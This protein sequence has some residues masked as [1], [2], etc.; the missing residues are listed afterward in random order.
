MLVH[1]QINFIFN[2]MSTSCLR[3]T[4]IANGKLQSK[5][6]LAINVS[7]TQTNREADI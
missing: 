5:I 6:R 1:Y 3:N 2:S 7:T 4:N